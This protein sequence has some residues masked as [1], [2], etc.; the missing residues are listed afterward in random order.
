MLKNEKVIR[1]QGGFV[2]KTKKKNGFGIYVWDLS[3][4]QCYIGFWKNGLM[5]GFGMMVHNNEIKYGIWENGFKKK[6]LENNNSLY[7]YAKWMNKR[8]N[9]LF[10]EKP[11]GIF[12]FLDN[13]CT[14]NNEFE[15]NN[16]SQL[17][18][19]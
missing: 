6:S 9:K 14:I 5:D 13:I 2:K 10:L 18:K 17:I 4:F 19:K 11:K 3:I 7:S 16:H 8:Y 1:Y 15:I 12:D